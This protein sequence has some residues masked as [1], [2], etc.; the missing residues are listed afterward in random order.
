MNKERKLKIAESIIDKSLEEYSIPDYEMMSK[1]Q[2]VVQIGYLID[3]LKDFIQHYDEA[4]INTIAKLCESIIETAVGIGDKYGEST[5]DICLDIMEER[6]EYD[7]NTGVFDYFPFGLK[8]IFTFM[9]T[10]YLRMKRSFHEDSVYDLINYTVFMVMWLYH[11][12]E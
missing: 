2:L 6:S 4:N 1:D 9:H 10:K 8:S 3:G 11:R 7:T 5:A 12:D